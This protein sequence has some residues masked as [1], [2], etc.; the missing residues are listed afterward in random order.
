MRSSSILCP[1]L[2]AA[3][4]SFCAV[5]SATAG[6]HESAPAFDVASADSSARDSYDPGDFA[7]A[8]HTN[9]GVKPWHKFPVPG[10]GLRGHWSRMQYADPEPRDTPSM[11][12]DPVRNRLVLFGGFD[13]SEYHN[14]TWVVNPGGETEWRRLPTL[15]SPPPGRSRHVAVY[16]PQTD[17]M[18]VYGGWDGTRH[19]GDIWQLD[20]GEVARWRAVT[21]LDEPRPARR[22]DCEGVYDAAH[23]RLVIAAGQADDRMLNDVWAFGLD[24]GHWSTVSPEAREEVSRSYASCAFD[25]RRQRW[26]MFGSDRVNDLWSWD[27]ARHVGWARLDYAD[28]G[29][30]AIVDPAAVYDSLRDQLIVVGG[31]EYPENTMEVSI[32]DLSRQTRGPRPRIA[33]DPPPSLVSPAAV[34]DPVGDR[35]LV[36]GGLNRNQTATGEL[37]ALSLGDSMRWTRLSTPGPGMPGPRAFASSVYDPRLKRWVIMFGSNGTTALKDVWN[38]DFA[39]GQ[40]SENVFGDYGGFPARGLYAAST[41]YD[42]VR[43]RVLIFGGTDGVKTYR[44]VW[45]FLMTPETN[46]LQPTTFNVSGQFPD[47]AAGASAFYDVSR[48]RMLVFNVGGSCRCYNTWILRTEGSTALWTPWVLPDSIPRPNVRAAAVYDP[49]R[50]RLVQAAG[51]MDSQ[52]FEPRVWSIGLSDALPKWRQDGVGL[53]ADGGRGAYDPAGRRMLVFGGDLGAV[54]T[55]ALWEVRMS[56]G[57]VQ[58]IGPLGPLPPPR[59]LHA[60][61]IDA[62]NRRLFAFGGARYVSTNRGLLGDLWELD[63]AG[64]GTWRPLIASPRFP[65]QRSVHA[66]LYDAPR[67]RM[68]VFGGTTLDDSVWAL[69]LSGPL[70][71]SRLPTAGPSPG[72]RLGPSLVYDSRRDRAIMIG[73]SRGRDLA[74]KDAWALSLSD[75]PTWSMIEP[76]DT[77][78][79]GGENSACVYDSSRDEVISFGGDATTQRHRFEDWHFRPGAFALSL[80][81]PNWRGLEVVGGPAGN[82]T[83]VAAVITPGDRIMSYGGLNDV[84]GTT[85]DTWSIGLDGTHFTHLQQDPCSGPPAAYGPTLVRDPLRRLALLYGGD[86]SVWARPDDGSGTWTEI[87]LTSTPPAART[88]FSSIY[89]TRHQRMVVWGGHRKTDTIDLWGFTLDFAS[90]AR[91]PIVPIGP[92]QRFAVRVTSPARGAIDAA[93]SLPDRSPARLE[94]YDIAGRRVVT[95]DVGALGAGEHHIAIPESAHLPAGIYL[96]RLRRGEDVRTARIVL[97]EH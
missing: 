76:R 9:S 19:L 31:S 63:L 58:R 35:V 14:D 71:W 25:S 12:H 32:I 38:Y 84:L 3:V 75:P 6:D 57:M 52:V 64:Q 61:A 60:V 54:R 5:A 91:G 79:Q 21:Q 78:T 45:Q 44:D 92:G 48:D 94:F 37:W 93:I 13:G 90:P 85:C 42:P 65:E 46:Q 97:L 95:R 15:G 81:D 87:N 70:R 39:T 80:S 16:D 89:D 96:L 49:E 18:I 34:Y 40:W 47:Y 43:N 4:L 41:A 55:N 10:I 62:Q 36:F 24:T 2:L 77:L 22:G 50:D 73:G 88:E 86:G 30:I 11:I 69:P 23:H 53:A 17:A 82:S 74:M 67:D 72:W 68:L 8:P 51:W 66:A 7:S 33:G 20:L 59:F 29:Q 28:D 56:D 26:L 1:I 27:V 83:N